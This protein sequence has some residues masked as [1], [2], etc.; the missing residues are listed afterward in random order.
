MI[1]DRAIAVIEHNIEATGQCYDQFVLSPECM[2]MSYFTSGY[3]IYPVASLH[4]K[5]ESFTI[6]YERQVASRVTYLWQFYKSWAGH[7]CHCFSVG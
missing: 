4:V 2:T 6:L 7:W 5:A 3:I 1:S